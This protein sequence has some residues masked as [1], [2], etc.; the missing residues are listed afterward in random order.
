MG[1][2]AE[3]TIG[4]I[5]KRYE[6]LSKAVELEKIEALQHLGEMCV[7]HA[8]NVS[9][10]KGFFDRTGNL[11]SSIGYAV[12][13]DGVAVHSNYPP[14]KVAKGMIKEKRTARRKLKDGTIKTYTYTAKV[15]IGGSGEVGAAQGKT[16]AQKIGE[17]TKGVA[18]VVTAGMNYAVHVESKGRD[19]ISGAELFAKKELPKMLEQIQKDIIEA[20]K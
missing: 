8:R 19:V 9:P 3:F 1:I 5:L 17:Q 4:D 6:A 12:F 14:V 18:L 16:L 15:K 20:A 2:K 13:L 7:S 11:R 10:P